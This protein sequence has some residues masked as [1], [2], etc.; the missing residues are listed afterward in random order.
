MTSCGSSARGCRRGRAG[1]D[2]FARIGGEEFAVVMPDTG[3]EGALAAARRMRTAVASSP[4]KADTKSLPVTASLGLCAIERG[5]AGQER[6]AERLVK[7]ADAA[8][9]RSK[10]DGRR[11]RPTATVLKIPGD[12]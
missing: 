6:L 3:Y 1:V 12:V 7:T 5:P 2:W 9:Y 10:N 4:F 8:P 11:N